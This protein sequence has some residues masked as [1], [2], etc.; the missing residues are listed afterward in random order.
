MAVNILQDQPPASPSRPSRIDVAAAFAD[1]PKPLDFVLPGMLAGTVGALVS[2]GGAGKSMM[3]LQL[4]ALVAGGIDLIGFDTQIPQGRVVILAAEDPVE[5]LIHRLH[6]LGTRMDPQ[7]R[8]LMAHGVDIL[9]LL[10]YGFDVMAPDWLAWILEQAQGTRLLIIDT[11]RRVH[12]LDENDGGSMAALL[13]Q[14]ERIVHLTGCTILFL[15]HSSKAAALQG[16]GDMQQASRGSSVLVDN[17]RWQSYM[18]AMSREEAKTFDVDEERRGFFVRWGVSKQNYGK[19]VQEC[20]LQRHD[21]GVLLPASL[22]TSLQ[23][24]R[25]GERGHA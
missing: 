8:E 13:A 21:G 9:P 25:N 17:I 14:L 5:A 12:T 6:A 11:L 7:R 24:R 4:S 1:E 19:P 16:Q 10:G 18:A 23:R 3:A 20:W 2:P 22:S 15:H